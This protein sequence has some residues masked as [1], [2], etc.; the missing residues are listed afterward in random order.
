MILLERLPKD[1][2]V[3]SLPMVSLPLD[4]PYKVTPDNANRIV[5][6][7]HRNVFPPLM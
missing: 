5:N 4:S 2:A 3:P 7:T 1:R 6:K